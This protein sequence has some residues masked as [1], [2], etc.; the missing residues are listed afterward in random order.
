MRDEKFQEIGKNSKF[1]NVNSRNEIV[2]KGR[3][4]NT[5]ALEAYKGFTFNV[6]PT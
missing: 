1:Y 6:T 2:I 3:D 4:G 5:S